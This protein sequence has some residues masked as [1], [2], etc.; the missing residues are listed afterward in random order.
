[1]AARLEQAA[2]QAGHGMLSARRV[3]RA[4]ED[5]AAG[6][7]PCLCAD[8]EAAR[9]LWPLMGALGL[10][11]VLGRDGFWRAVLQVGSGSLEG[12]VLRIGWQCAS[13]PALPGSAC[14]EGGPLDLSHSRAS[15]A[16]HVWPS[17]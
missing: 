14:H 6:L 16:T 4:E 3:C 11:P 9:V 8:F 5:V 1:M 2:T 13:L 17:S 7:A 15:V 10:L 12:A